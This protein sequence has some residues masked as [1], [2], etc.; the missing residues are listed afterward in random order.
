[1][2]FL[3]GRTLSGDGSFLNGFLCPLCDDV[4]ERCHA[5]YSSMLAVSPSQSPGEDMV[6]L[7]PCTNTCAGSDKMLTLVTWCCVC[8]C[9]IYGLEPV[10]AAP[11]EKLLQPCSACRLN[12]TILYTQQEALAQKSALPRPG[13]TGSCWQIPRLKLHSLIGLAQRHLFPWPN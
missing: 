2:P 9:V 1:M 12:G 8:H 7:S 10:S 4:Q 3:P 13:G 6:K 5:W 11:W